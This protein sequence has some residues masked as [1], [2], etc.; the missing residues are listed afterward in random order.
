MYE[1]GYHL[2]VDDFAH[3]RQARRQEAEQFRMLKATHSDSS[4]VASS[5]GHFLASVTERARSWLAPSPTPE[6][7]C[8]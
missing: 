2:H 5:L 3:R 7:Q 8:C 4:G 6:G 1:T